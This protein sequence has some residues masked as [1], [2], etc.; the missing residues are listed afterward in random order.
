M[1]KI[2][3]I[4]ILEHLVRIYPNRL[5]VDQKMVDA[6]YFHLK[7]YDMDSIMK[8]ILA[9]ARNNR[10]PPT[11]ADLIEGDSILPDLEYHTIFGNGDM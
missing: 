8:K 5:E 9:H 1:R 6:W 7:Y 11:I 2:E 10:F 4:D 3:V